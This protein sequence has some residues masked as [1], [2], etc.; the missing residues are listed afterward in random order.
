MGRIVVGV[1][2]S[3]ESEAALHWALR[4]AASTDSAV[5]AIMSWNEH[6]LL[7]G[8]SETLGGGVPLELVQ[9]Q[10]EG[11][12]N[13]TIAAATPD[14]NTVTITKETASGPPSDLLVDASVEAELVVVGRH[15][16]SGL[17]QLGSVSAYVARH[18]SCPVVVVPG[19]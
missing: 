11:L 12:L 18:A 15:A 16:K 7:A 14:G 10:A 3:P 1:D 6:P 19:R 2:G 9:Q 5:H 13:T 4:Q 17:V 8:V